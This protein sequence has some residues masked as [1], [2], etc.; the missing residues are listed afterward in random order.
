MAKLSVLIGGDDREL[1]KALKR[2]QSSLQHFGRE[3]RAGA[4]VAA[5]WGVMIAAAALTAS[6]AIIKGAMDAIDAQA[7]LA[8]QNNTTVASMA[9]LEAVSKT[10]GIAMETMAMAGKALAVRLGE[11]SQ[12]QGEAAKTMRRLQLTA[13]ELVALPLDER[14]ARINERIFQLIPATQRAAVAADLFGSR[15]A[16]MMLQ[17]SPEVIREARRI[18]RT[19]APR[20][21][22]WTPA[23]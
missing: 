23:K 4:S 11:A 20:C 7:K 3:M 22:T 19:L 15:A 18:Q 1:Q 13:A 6:A 5:K 17:L 10:S 2:S 16:Q 9:T 8:Q 14:I 21:P 12:G